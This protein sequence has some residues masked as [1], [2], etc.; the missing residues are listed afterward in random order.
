MR[1]GK[2]SAKNHKRNSMA[3]AQNQPYQ[4]L[5][6]QPKITS[7]RNLVTVGQ[8]FKKQQLETEQKGDKDS[9]Q[10]LQTL[11]CMAVYRD[12]MPRGEILTIYN[13]QMAPNI[14]SDSV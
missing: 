11:S 4:T 2:K 10:H 7:S 13:S 1:E 9:A 6:I 14:R 5:R 3:A 8:T 12:T